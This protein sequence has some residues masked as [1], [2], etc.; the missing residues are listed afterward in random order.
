MYK[1]KVK[2]PTDWKHL[3]SLS[4]AGAILGCDFAGTVVQVGADV[5]GVSKGDKVG[6]FVHGGKFEDKGSYAEYAKVPSDMLLDLNGVDLKE[7][8]TFGIGYITAAMVSQ[9]LIDND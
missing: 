6:T 5:K 1:A 3:D 2:N 9:T 8:V 4:P 7:G